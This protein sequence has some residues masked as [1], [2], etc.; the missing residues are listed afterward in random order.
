MKRNSKA[1]KPL[2]PA[3]AFGI[4]SV[5]A[6]TYTPDILVPVAETSDPMNGLNAS[7]RMA[8]NVSTRFENIGAFTPGSISPLRTRT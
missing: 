7:F 3:A 6:Q 2:I 5:A 8:F 4:L 1:L